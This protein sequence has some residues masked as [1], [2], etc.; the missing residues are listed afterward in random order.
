MRAPR[1]PPLIGA[2]DSASPPLTGAARHGFLTGKRATCAFPCRS[3]N[4][5]ISQRSPFLSYR[6]ASS[7]RASWCTRVLVTKVTFVRLCHYTPSTLHCLSTT[8]QWTLR[9]QPFH[10][11]CGISGAA[12]AY[13][14]CVPATH[15][16]CV[17]RP[18]RYF[19][20]HLQLGAQRRVCPRHAFGFSPNGAKDCIR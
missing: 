2:P 5:I 11:H 6:P 15:S 3:S 20:P 19:R 1:A 4:A 8:I 9:D 10:R 13:L 17:G 7:H 12:S 14:E 16:N 18:A